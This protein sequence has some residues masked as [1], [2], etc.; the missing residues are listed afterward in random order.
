M[1]LYVFYH[2]G[3]KNRMADDASCLF[4]LSDTSL[5]AHMSSVYPQSQSLLMT[6]LLPTYLLS[7][8]ISTLRRRPCEQ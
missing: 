5:L 1:N 2:P 3:I 4:E 7:C 6:S 8:V